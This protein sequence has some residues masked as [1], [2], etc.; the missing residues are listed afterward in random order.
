MTWNFTIT[1]YGIKIEEVRGEEVVRLIAE[2]P[3]NFEEE[4]EAICNAHN[5][6]RP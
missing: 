6:A 4:A 3:S 5:E 2:L 1:E